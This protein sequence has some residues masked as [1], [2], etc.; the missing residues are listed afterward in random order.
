MRRDRIE[1]LD[2]LRG[3][4]LL[5]MFLVHFNERASGGGAASGVSGVYQR[6]VILFFE[7]RFWTMF[8]ILFGVG[9]AV[10]LRRADERGGSFVPLYVR[11]LIVLAGFGVFAHAVLGFNVLLGY[12]I[13][14]LPLLLVRRWSIRALIAAVLISAAS[15]SLY[16]I[17]RVSGCA[18]ASGEAACR[19]AVSAEAAR[20][21]R[22]NAAN[23]ELQH[24][25]DFRSVVGARLA[26]MRWFYAQPFSFLPVNTFTLFLIGVIALRLG[27]FDAPQDHRRALSAFMAFGVV[28]WI[29]SR[30]LLG[31]P[32]GQPQPGTLVRQT[33]LAQLANG[34]G[35]IR[36]TWLTFTY[37][38]GVL[39][40]TAWDPRWLR[41][42][43]AFGWTG[44]MALTNYLL[45]IAI[46]DFSFS[47]Y[48]WH[49]TATPLGALAGGLTLF[50]ADALICRWWL[51]RFRLGP[52]EWVWRS[53]T[54]GRLEP[55]REPAP[56]E[57]SMMR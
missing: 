38:G 17:A 18:A 44:R 9:F 34:F 32:V 2:V 10:Q 46:L 21:Q 51:A 5:G 43:A 22:F 33:V 11:R 45:Q 3:I 48:G 27:F 52:L 24:S 29:A 40:L 7:E 14:A 30:W 1:V 47:N 37:M 20:N 31:A 26:H 19:A 54:Y 23:R 12:A 55:W 57:A 25:P 4:A 28:S 8:G 15:W 35:L 42:L 13:W 50:A 39:L 56:A 49:L 16:S 41:R 6:A 53:A 36:G